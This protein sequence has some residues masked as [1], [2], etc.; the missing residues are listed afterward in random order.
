MTNP[1]QMTEDEAKVAVAELPCRCRQG[2]IV[3]SHIK[4]GQGWQCDDCARTG[5]RYP[6]LSEPCDQ[7]EA[8]STPGAHEE[9][10]YTCDGTKRVP[11]VE[12]E[13]VMAAGMIAVRPHQ[14]SETL[15]FTGWEARSAL[16]QSRAWP[17]GKTPLHAACLAL[18]LAHGEGR[19]IYE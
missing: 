5:R 8:Y 6:T 15:E 10:C 7:I 1:R 3:A 14:D 11:S 12:L 2:E 17:G 9:H 13:K 19:V 4:P 16:T 18:L